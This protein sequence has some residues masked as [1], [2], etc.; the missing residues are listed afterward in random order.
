MLDIIIMWIFRLPYAG[1]ILLV[2]GFVFFKREKVSLNLFFFSALSY[3]IPIIYW[4]IASPSAF[5]MYVIILIFLLFYTRKSRVMM[6]VFAIFL[7]LH[8]VVALIL[9][10]IFWQPIVP[11]SHT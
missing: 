1:I 11:P 7:L 3:L 6:M 10:L 8:Y 9:L 4:V 2:G 5:I